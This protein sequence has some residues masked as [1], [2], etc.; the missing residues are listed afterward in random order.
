MH[1]RLYYGGIFLERIRTDVGLFRRFQKVQIGSAGPDRE[2][3]V[4]YRGDSVVISFEKYMETVGFSFASMGICSRWYADFASLSDHNN[5]GHF[6]WT[7]FS[8]YKPTLKA[9]IRKMIY[10]DYTWSFLDYGRKN[11]AIRH[12]LFILEINRLLQHNV[13]FVY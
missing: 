11:L 10:W 3:R 8:L 12:W 13:Q 1:W 7:G 5:K 4:S 6:Q 9:S 2:L